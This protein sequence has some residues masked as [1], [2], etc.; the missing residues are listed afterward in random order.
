MN[1]DNKVSPGQANANRCALIR[2]DLARIGAVHDVI[3]FCSGPGARF[4]ADGLVRNV[5]AIDA[6][7]ALTELPDRA[8]AEVVR[9]TIMSLTEIQ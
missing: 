8:G 2:T 5:D 6:I 9:A 7:R 3:V 1:D 4:F